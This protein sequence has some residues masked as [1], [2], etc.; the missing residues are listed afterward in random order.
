MTGIVLLSTDV[1]ADS[2]VPIFDPTKAVSIS[3][4]IMYNNVEVAL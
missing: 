3:I 2:I 1:F 4:H